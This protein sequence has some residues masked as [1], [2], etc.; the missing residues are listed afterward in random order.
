MPVADDACVRSPIVA[1]TLMIGGCVTVTR[2]PTLESDAA[3]AWLREAADQRI[4][5]DAPRGGVPVTGRIAGITARAV[6]LRGDDGGAIAIPVEVGTTLQRRKRGEGAL[7]GALAGTGIGLV[8]GALLYQSL[9][10][11][12]PD[13]AGGREHP[14]F[15]IPL[16]LLAGAVVGAIIG[17]AVGTESRLEVGPNSGPGS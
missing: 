14:P 4:E 7:L 5:I 16:G 3:R 1:L 15:M 6:E 17:A 11:P 12:N 2:T 13:S 10:T 9:S 8:T